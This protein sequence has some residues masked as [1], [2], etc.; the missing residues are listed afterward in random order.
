[1]ILVKDADY[2]FLLG[3]HCLQIDSFKLDSKSDSLKDI[4]MKSGFRSV[5]MDVIDASGGLKDQVI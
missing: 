3:K 2:S 1:V 5:I 4:G